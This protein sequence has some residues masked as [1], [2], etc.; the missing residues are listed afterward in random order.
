MSPTM[1]N[2]NTSLI[3]IEE[4]DM[5]SVQL[6]NDDINNGESTSSLI[7]AE[8]D[9]IERCGLLALT[10]ISRQQLIMKRQS[11]NAIESF[12]EYSHVQKE[13]YSARKNRKQEEQK[14]KPMHIYNKQ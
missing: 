3:S 6:D 8:Q 9:D 13:I 4:D 5:D 12:S 14:T 7:K 10:R 2:K 11:D 1:T